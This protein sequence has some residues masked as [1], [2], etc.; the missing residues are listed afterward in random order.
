MAKSK[1]VSQDTV[2]SAN[3]VKL[4]RTEIQDMKVVAVCDR[5]LTDPDTMTLVELEN[6]I[7]NLRC[8]R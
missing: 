8:E 6:T 3:A 7:G 2:S 5:V 4:V 1:V